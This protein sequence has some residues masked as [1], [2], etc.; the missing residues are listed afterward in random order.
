MKMHRQNSL[1][2]VCEEL[3]YWRSGIDVHQTQLSVCLSSFNWSHV[4]SFVLDIAFLRLT[5]VP[6]LNV[7]AFFSFFAPLT[8]LLFLI[9]SPLSLALSL[10]SICIKPQ[11]AQDVLMNLCLCFFPWP[12]HCLFQ[13]TEADEVKRKF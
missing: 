3:P 4:V 5:R 10:L 8:L 1:S 11:T 13:K 2:V 7:S 6:E 12:S 9:T